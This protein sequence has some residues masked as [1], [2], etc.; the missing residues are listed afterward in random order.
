M[1]QTIFQVETEMLTFQPDYKP[2]A[3]QLLTEVR[4]FY[5]DPENEAAF[6]RWNEERSEH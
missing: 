3:A 2:L 6:Q 4:E 5:A 1:T